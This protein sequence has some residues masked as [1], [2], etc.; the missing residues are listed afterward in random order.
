MVQAF[1][2]AP[3]ASGVLEDPTSVGRLRCLGNSP[4]YM[5]QHLNIVPCLSFCGDVQGRWFI[6]LF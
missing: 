2:E 1:P 6:F 3:M 4:G 5:L